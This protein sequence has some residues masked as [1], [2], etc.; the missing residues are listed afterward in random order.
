MKIKNKTENE[1][2]IKIDRELKILL[3]NAM[4]KGFF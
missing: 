1:A 3:L 4:Q 2:S